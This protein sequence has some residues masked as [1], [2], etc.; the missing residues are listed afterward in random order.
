VRVLLVEDEPTL[1]RTTAAHL[2]RDGFA[3]DV[4]ADGPEALHKLT[5][6]DYDLITLDIL[7]PG[8]NGYDVLRR[9]RAQEVRTPVLMLT[10][11]DGEWDLSDALELGADDYL[12]KPFSYVVLLARLRALLRRGPATRR[13]VLTLGPVVVDCA[14]RRVSVA[15]RDV[16]VTAREVAVLEHLAV[17]AGEVVSK[18]D[19]LEHVWDENFDGDPNIVEVYVGYLRRKLAIPSGPGRIETV[20]GSGYRLVTEEGA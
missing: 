12:V 7:L 11:K 3:V 5:R 20:R 1:A 18:R 10:A 9:L 4:A 8:L 6:T 2:A 19:L 16:P 13:P 15:G 17:H 14:A